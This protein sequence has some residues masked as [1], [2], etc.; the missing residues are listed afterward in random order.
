M[1]IFKIEVKKC[2]GHP[3]FELFSKFAAESVSSEATSNS[4]ELSAVTSESIDRPPILETVELSSMFSSPKRDGA[5]DLELVSSSETTF[6]VFFEVRGK[7]LE[8]SSIVFN[9]DLSSFS[10]GLD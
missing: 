9:S 5:D 7:S 10:S 2:L 3:S 4:D 8:H 1:F 6:F